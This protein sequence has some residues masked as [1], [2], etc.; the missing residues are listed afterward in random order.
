MGNEMTT[1]GIVFFTALVVAAMMGQPA[2]RFLLAWQ[3]VDR[4]GER[5]SHQDPTVRGGGLGFITVILGGGVWLGGLAGWLPLG[6]ILSATI[7]LA[8]ISFWDDLRSLGP[9]V[10]FGAHSVAGLATLACL[11]WPSLVLALQVGDGIVLPAALGA[12]LGFFWLVGYTNAFNFMDGINGLAG[13][14]AILTGAG[15]AL[16]AGLA[17]GH[18]DSPPVIFAWLVAG[19]AAGFLPYNCPHPRMFMG[20]VGSAPLGFLL[21]VLVLW[22]ARDLGSWLL[23]P[24]LL[25]HA[26]FILDTGITLTR[27]IA[28]GE[29]WFHPHREHFYQ[30]LLRSGRSHL[31]VTLWEVALQVVVFALLVAYLYVGVAVR[32]G[33]VA[34]VLGLW[35][36]FFLWCEQ[37]F[38]RVGSRVRS[39]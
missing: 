32:I 22:M 26:N 23:I 16:L 14:Q 35:G 1:G 25:L 17:S 24:L 11:G 3:I 37:S 12:L 30:R 19:A 8:A 15:S 27:R 20:D 5:S 6:G 21:A 34:S 36:T 33:I 2:Y 29:K 18:W 13:F 31:S 9:A 4:P 7:L 10:R 38:Q 39:S 28:R